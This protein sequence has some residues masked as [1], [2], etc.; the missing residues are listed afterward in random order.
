MKDYSE[1]Q[2]LDFVMGNLPDEQYDEILKARKTN[3][4]LDNRI[5]A[6]AREMDELTLRINYFPRFYFLQS[7][8]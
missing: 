3:L 1:V 4:D 5:N 8:Y 6:L 7:F 2:L